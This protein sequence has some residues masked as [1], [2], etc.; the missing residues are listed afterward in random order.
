MV[1]ED[2][3]YIKGKVFC[4][5]DTD[6]QI[7]NSEANDYPNMIAR[8]LLV[9]DDAINLVKIHSKDVSP[10][11]EIEDCLNAEMFV[12]ALSNFI[13]NEDA[14]SVLESIDTESLEPGGYSKYSLNLRPTEERIL[15]RFFDGD[16]GD[17]KLEFA[18]AY[19]IFYFFVE[20]TELPWIK[21]I[22]EFLY[23]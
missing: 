16:G 8:R 6:A 18:R 7:V 17:N 9:C 14:K 20:N 22:K 11:T 2:K 19:N 1:L 5:T 21:Q 13:S 3:K 15:K 12:G 10:A 23:K 4:L